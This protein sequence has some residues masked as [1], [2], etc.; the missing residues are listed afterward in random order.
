VINIF[1]DDEKVFTIPEKRGIIN[2]GGDS[3]IDDRQAGGLR[4]SP[5]IN[6]SEAEINH[7]IDEIRA[8][9]ADERVFVFNSGFKTGYSDDFQ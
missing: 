6:L 5:F 7:L 9:E 3:L 8:I 4:R 2:M 1:N